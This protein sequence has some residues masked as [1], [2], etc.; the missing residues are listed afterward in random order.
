MEAW[1]QDVSPSTIENCW[2]KSRV[3]SARYG[4]RNLGEANDLRVEKKGSRGRKY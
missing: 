3:L 2:V 4:P 1:E